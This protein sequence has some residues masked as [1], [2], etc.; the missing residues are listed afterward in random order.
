MFCIFIFFLRFYIF[1]FFLCVFYIFKFLTFYVFKLF[2]VFFTF[3][4]AFF[5]HKFPLFRKITRRW[6]N[7]GWNDMWKVN[8]NMKSWI[9][10]GLLY[11]FQLREAFK[12]NGESWESNSNPPLANL[13]ILNCYFF[14]GYLGLID[15]EMDFEMNLFFSLT[16]VVW[17]LEIFLALPY[18]WYT[19]K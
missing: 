19:V 2:N 8:K 16:K 18:I 11:I 13:G 14:I 12:K 7:L 10:L 6:P 1:V 9:F 15:H 3:L 4:H 5:K 17:H